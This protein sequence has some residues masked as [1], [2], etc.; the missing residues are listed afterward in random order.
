MKAGLRSSVKVEMHCLIT[1]QLVGSREWLQGFL[2][3][4]YTGGSVVY[5]IF[6]AIFLHH[7]VK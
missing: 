4:H 1:K 2:F 7:A 5:I 6:R 3:R